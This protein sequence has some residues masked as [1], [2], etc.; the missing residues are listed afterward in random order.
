MRARL[1]TGDLHPPTEITGFDP[2]RTIPHDSTVGPQ[3]PKPPQQIHPIGTDRGLRPPY[4][5]QIPEVTG[6]RHH[7]H[8]IRIEQLIRLVPIARRHQLT[9]PRNH[10][11]RQIPL[12]L[13]ISDHER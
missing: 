12:G 4:R 11:C 6:D 7:G 13:S 2:R 1:L 10:Q 5:Q 8:A 9:P 3:E